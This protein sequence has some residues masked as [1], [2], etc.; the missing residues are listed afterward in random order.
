MPVF[1]TGRANF[2]QTAQKCSLGYPGPNFVAKILYLIFKVKNSGKTLLLLNNLGSVTAICNS[3]HS[4]VFILQAPL[5]VSL[6][7]TYES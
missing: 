1:E 6:I 4:L 3:L 7:M 2:D 5:A